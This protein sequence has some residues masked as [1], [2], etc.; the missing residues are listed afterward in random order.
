MYTQKGYNCSFQRRLDLPASKRI[1]VSY[2]ALYGQ[3]WGKITKLSAEYNIS[4]QFIYNL[5][6]ALLLFEQNYFKK[7]EKVEKAEQK[8]KSIKAILSFRLEGKCSIESISSIMGRL[9]LGYNSVGFISERLTEIGKKVGNDLSKINAEA[10]IQLAFCSDEIFANQM[11]I[12]IT[13]DSFSLMILRIESSENRKSESWE[14]HWTSILAQ[15]YTPI[16]IAKD[17][18]IGMKAAQSVVCPDIPCQSDTFHAVAHRLGLWRDRLEKA[19]YGSIE[20]EYECLRLLGNSKSEEVSNR[21]KIEYGVA[22][23]QANRAIELYDMFTFLYYCLLEC[24]QIFDVAGKLKNTAQIKADF[25]VA[26]DLIK[27][28]NQHEINEEVKSINSCKSTL[29]YFSETAKEVVTLLSQTID[30]EVLQLL[31]LA[32]QTQK[33]SIK[34]KNNPERKKVLK[35][36]EQ[37]LLQQVEGLLG[38]GYEATKKEVYARLDQIIQSSASVECINSI[39]R[40]YLN[41]SK[42]QPTQELLNLFMF[43]HNHRRFAQGKR[44]G[45]T[46]SELFFGE[47]QPEDWL[48]LLLEKTGN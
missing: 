14:K 43:Y 5:R 36:R 41:T 27:S 48:N 33:N 44:K 16:V 24:F 21:R 40:P 30:N 2:K 3:G 4:R 25:D 13:V 34:I 31:C 32:H 37:Q 28:L 46:P 12:L 29:F 20:K 15:G 18:G 7:N 47:P 19:A 22:Q 35:R 39:L 8:L 6:A 23:N 45:K 11:P 10:P 38:L 26:L 42:N 1:E 17:E 9:G